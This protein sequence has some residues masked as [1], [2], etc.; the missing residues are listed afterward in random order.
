MTNTL[1]DLLQRLLM[2]V[3]LCGVP[4][5]AA[6]EAI[7]TFP[8][9]DGAG[10]NATGGRGGIVY[11]VTRLDGE[12]NGNRNVAGTFGYGI[13]DAN[14]PKDADG[15]VQPRT[16]VF[17]VGGTIWLGRVGENEGW[18]NQDPISAGTTSNKSSNITI[19]GQTAPGGITIMGGTLK[20]NGH[21]IVVRN[22][23]IA[24]GYGMRGVGADGIPDS[25]VFD[26]MNIHAHDVMVD[27]LS[28]FFAT[29]ET[30]SMDEFAN[31]VTVEYS[32]ISQGQNYPQAD[33]ENAG[34]YTG[35]ALGSLIQPGTG[36]AISVHHNLYAQQKGRLP[37]VGSEVGTGAYNDF[38][39]NVFYN[40]L[41]TGGTGASGQ[42]SFNNFINNFWLAGP[43]GDN[44]T[45]AGTTIGTTAGGTQIFN[46]SSVASTRVY[47]SGNLKDI[48]KDGDAN[49]GVATTAN[50][51]SSS[52][53]DFRTVTVQATPY[54]Q[55]PYFGVTDTATSAHNRVLNYVGADWWTRDG[56]INTVDER[57]I[58]EVRT[59]TGKIIAWADNPNDP[60]DGQEW[61]SLLAKRPVA[62]VAPYNRPANFDT[63]GDGMPDAWEAEHG[64]NPSVADN[65]GDFDSDGYTNLEEYLNETA[66][67]PAPQ[68]I[69]F[70]GT[71]N[72]R[73][74][75]ITNWDIK[76]QPSK[77]DEA[78]INSGTAVVDAVGQHAGI[79]RIGAHVGDNGTL[80]VT[81]G[82]LH[83]ETATII[84][85]DDGATAAL[86]LS[87][88]E[89][90]TPILTKGV[91]GL[92]NFTGGILHAD[93][94]AFDLEND[95]GII[96]T[97]HSPGLTHIIGSLLLA[98]GA[99][100][101]EIGGPADGQYDRLLVDGVAHLGGT[102]DVNLV[103]LGAG[104]YSPQLGDKFTFLA[105]QGGTDGEFADLSLPRLGTGLMWRL[106]TTTSLTR[107]EVVPSPEP[108][109][110]LS[111]S[112]AALGLALG[113]RVAARKDVS[114]RA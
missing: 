5:W 39:N 63:D 88:G 23:T 22:L 67:W 87:G 41:S 77:Y 58:N 14:F 82:W 47:Q 45:G 20:V 54:T 72:N 49:D 25:Y 74:A 33:A 24:P 69:V 2:A 99:L 31:N 75:Q 62:G 29:D 94:V 114:S 46:G 13:N 3:A 28:T 108:P 113:R 111:A 110:W 101:I 10:A 84:G 78:Q 7:P 9:A 17:D 70:N 11:H 16:I 89:L 81:A 26:A 6:A 52:S 71:A 107:L 51:S 64:L 93:V 100:E 86:N 18:D 35:H 15:N 102:L 37:R 85:G 12:V 98:A 36:A 96:A 109:T 55:V 92:F 32:N 56:V 80:N 38:R 8:G 73:F 48:N 91:G 4:G 83:V 79:I 112:I 65:N 27:H 95:G 44:P 30:I 103:D 90:S 61:F 76:W 104:I 59:G 53:F 43:G 1:P 40:W 68:P 21:N 66:E 19:A 60:N 106:D 50:A 42:P 105:S 97:G 34:V 57:I